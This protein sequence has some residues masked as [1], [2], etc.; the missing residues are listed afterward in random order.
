MKSCEAIRVFLI[1]DYQLVIDALSNAM[2]VRPDRFVLHGVS[3]LL[4]DH[5]PCNSHEI[6]VV[7]LDMDPNPD[8][9]MDWFG[10]RHGINGP[11]WVLVCRHQ[12]SQLQ[13]GKIMPGAYGVLGRQ[14][15]LEETLQAIED[16]HCDNA[17]DVENAPATHPSPRAP[18]DS[19]DTASVVRLLLNLT[20]KERRIVNTLL[21]SGGEP[22]KVIAQKMF[23]SESTLRTHLTSIYL[24]LGVRNRIELVS[25]AARTG[26]VSHLS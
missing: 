23:I 4:S 19:T 15:S 25:Q 9:A 20:A 8:A 12:L 14:H 13:H 17:L 16:V 21:N 3:P 10:Y 18:Q 24:K 5:L 22:A 11:G 1:S 2:A 6:D 26:L 7:V